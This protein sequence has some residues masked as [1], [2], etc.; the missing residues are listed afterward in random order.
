MAC[1]GLRDETEAVRPLPLC[2]E[3]AH[4]QSNTGAVIRPHA[5]IF[6]RDGQQVLT[7][8]RRIAAKPLAEV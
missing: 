2:Q 4:W 6:M 5:V 1:T 7:C 8:S 3:C